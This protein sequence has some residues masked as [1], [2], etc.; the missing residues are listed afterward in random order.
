MPITK[1]DVEL[2]GKLAKMRI[3]PEESDMYQAQLEALF[4]WVKELSAVNTDAVEL[5]SVSQAAHV[6][7]D[8]PVCNEALAAQLRGAFAQE[9]A[10]CAKVKKVL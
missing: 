4:D 8:E 5:T 6:R 10:G 7:P 2:A 9:E 1:Q 3:S